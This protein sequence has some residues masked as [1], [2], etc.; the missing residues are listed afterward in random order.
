VVSVLA[1]GPKG[2]GFKPDQGDGFLRAIKIRST[3]SSGWEIKPD[4]PCLKILRH[5]KYL[6]KSHG[7]EE[8]EFSFPSTTL[9]LAPEMSRMAGPPDSTG[10]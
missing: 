9:P 1:A 3:L 10:G 4:V 8:T 2:C 5:L 7:D 6:L